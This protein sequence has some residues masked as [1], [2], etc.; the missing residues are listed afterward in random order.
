MINLEILTKEELIR[1]LGNVGDIIQTEGDWIGYGCCGS[2]AKILN[3][4][5]SAC[6]TYCSKNNSFDIGDIKLEIKHNR[7][8][9]HNYNKIK[10]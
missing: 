7:N 4:I 9:H 5:T 10:N 2:D 1:V 8:C 3:A 6:T